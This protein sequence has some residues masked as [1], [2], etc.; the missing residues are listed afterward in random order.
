MTTVTVDGMTFGDGL[1]WVLT[2]LGGWL[3]GPPVRGQKIDRPVDHG[4][5]A[6]PALRGGR[7]VTVE[8]Y[9]EGS[10]IADVGQVSDRLSGVLADG[11]FG[12]LTVTR[13]DGQT[14]SAS[15][16]V[17]AAPM[18]G[19]FPHVNAVA[20]QLQ[21]YAPDP[22]RYGAT[23]NLTTTFPELVG[24]LE[25][26]LFTDGAGTDVGWLDFGVAG[27]SGRVTVDNPGTAPAWPQFQVSGPTPPF[28]IVHVETGAR[29]T[30]SHALSADE[31][32]LIDSATGL[33]ALGDAAVDYSGYL[34]RA[35]WF[36]IPRKGSA[37]IAFVPLDV[38]GTGSLTVIHRPAW[39]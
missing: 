32:L 22:L 14:T 13:E 38:A 27:S 39:W 25:F 16:Q 19:W 21:F 4:G 28:E 5:F 34:T 31:V 20:A 6:I 29:L 10:S 11:E 33:V 17:D 36:S 24:G 7:V 1:P 2:D 9:V 26:D 15:V 18:V 12:E 8:A 35:E 23:Q 3:D 37:T 30:F